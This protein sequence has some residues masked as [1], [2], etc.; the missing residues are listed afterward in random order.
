MLTIQTLQENV[1][2]ET[3]LRHQLG[4]LAM[5]AREGSLADTWELHHRA[6]S[7][8]SMSVSTLIVE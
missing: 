5:S 3:P 7:A 1:V 6:A 2:S 4:L 8:K